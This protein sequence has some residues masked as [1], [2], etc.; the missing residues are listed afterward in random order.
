ME[1]Y[2]IRH[3]SVNVPAG[4]A[5][6]QTDVP[7]HPAFEEEAQTVKEKIT[8]LVFDKIWC[9]PLT[10]CVRLATY[11]GYQDTAV[12]D[13]RIKEISFGDWEM[14]TWEEISFDPRSAA[15][16]ADWINTRT[17]KG[18]SLMDQYKRVSTFLYE[19]KKS[20]LQKVCIFAHGGVLTCARVY[21][22]E[23]GIEDAFK[24]VPSYGAV[25]HIEI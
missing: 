1:I 2:L 18:E 17:P 15:W 7:L 4:Y 25:I 5:Y 12:W 24:N 16:F 10:R 14:K 20:D 23:Y 3:T 21:A 13:D 8:G 11:C 22:G 9:S 6:G 19:I